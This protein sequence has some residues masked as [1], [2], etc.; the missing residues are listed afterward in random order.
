MMKFGELSITPKME[1]P[2]EIMSKQENNFILYQDENGVT[3]MSVRFSD[4]D[5]WLT[6]LQSKKIGKTKPAAAKG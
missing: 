4:E 1:E 2:A 5:L 6:E 3:K